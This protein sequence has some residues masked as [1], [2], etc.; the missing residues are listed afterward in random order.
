MLKIRLASNGNFNQ[1]QPLKSLAVLNATSL[2]QIQ[3]TWDLANELAFKKA[4][5]S[6]WKVQRIANGNEKMGARL[7]INYKV[8]T[9]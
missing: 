8:V 7:S 3:P 4:V 5:F 1:K 2:S 6:M 9:A